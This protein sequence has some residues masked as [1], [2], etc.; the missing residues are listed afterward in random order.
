MSEIESSVILFVLT[1]VY[2]LSKMFIGN[3]KNFSSPVSQSTKN[4]T[5]QIASSITWR[6]LI[7]PNARA[8][9]S[10]PTA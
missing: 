7:L 2:L 5:V 4:G 3:S 1:E 10:N 9:G 8:V 6:G